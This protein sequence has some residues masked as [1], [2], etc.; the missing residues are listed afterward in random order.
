MTQS[1]ETVL[2]P[3]RILAAL[4][5][6]VNGLGIIYQR[7]ALRE[8]IQRGCRE[9]IEPSQLIFGRSIKFIAGFAFVLKFRPRI[10]PLGLIFFLIWAAWVVAARMVMPVWIQAR[11]IAVYL[12]V[13]QA[14]ITIGNVSWGMAVTHF[15]AR[16]E[17]MCAAAALL[18]TVLLAFQYSLRNGPGVDCSLA[19]EWPDPIFAQEVPKENAPVLVAVEYEI[20]IS[21][22][23]EFRARMAQ[24]EIFRRRN[25][26]L[27]SGLFADPQMPGKCLEDYLVESWLEYQKLH[28]R[29][30]VSDQQLHDEIWALHIGIDPPRVTH[31]F[32]DEH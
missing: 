14:G 30:T 4:V 26:A 9:A 5:F 12:L 18:L 19:L 10:T 28:Q 6:V 16:S 17:V 23:P 3:S 1:Q 25:G 29:V 27:Q 20:D 24:L 13:L 22:I 2:I 15:G 11:A 7:E 21:R 32:A 8:L 31:F